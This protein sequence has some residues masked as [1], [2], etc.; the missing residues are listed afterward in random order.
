M[1]LWY[2]IS[3]KIWRTYTM[4]KAKP[5]TLSSEDRSRLESITKTRTLQAQTVTRARILLLKADGESVDSIADKVDLNR[6]SVLLCLK[7]YNQGGIENAIYDAPGRGRNAEIT[8][9]EKTWIINIACQRPG[10]FGYSAE[11]WTYAKLTEHINK[12][13]ESAGYS[14]NAEIVLERALK[15][16][17]LP[18]ST[19][20]F[21]GDSTFVYVLTDS[22]PQQK[23]KRQ[24]IEVGMSD[25]IKI[26]VK[27]GLTA[28][29][30]VRGAEKSDK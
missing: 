19:V 9:D 7:K 15:T 30:K 11:T 24:Q 8:D 17:A 25:G 13:A 4:A 21:S 22:I 16:L 1:F 3:I 2:T 27:S 14:A 12:T 5:L 20:E 18:E 10:E 23:F 6:N 26:A 29:D 28:K